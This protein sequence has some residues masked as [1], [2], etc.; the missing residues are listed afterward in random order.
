MADD[1][2]PFE[3]NWEAVQEGLRAAGL[4]CPLRGLY[5]CVW[6]GRPAL[7]IR[8]ELTDVRALHALRDQLMG[9]MSSGA[10]RP[11]RRS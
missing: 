9:K 7:R 1:S 2:A 6:Q 8:L 4:D 3:L 11:K 5:V 10:P